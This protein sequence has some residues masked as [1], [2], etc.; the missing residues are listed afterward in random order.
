[1]ST[2]TNLADATPS[3]DQIHDTF[4][5]TGTSMLDAVWTWVSRTSV[6]PSAQASQQQFKKPKWATTTHGTTTTLWTVSPGGALKE[7]AQI[8]W[9]RAAEKRVL[10]TRNGRET[11]AD[12][13]LVKSKG[14]FGGSK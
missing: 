9:S 7:Y 4:R 6:S 1:M 3:N 14:L 8:C 5:I 13:L 2:I 12:Q 11:D 10:V